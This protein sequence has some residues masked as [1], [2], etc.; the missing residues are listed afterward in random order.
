MARTLDGKVALVTGGGTVILS[1][2]SATRHM[3]RI[4]GSRR[5]MS[6]H[7]STEVVH[8]AHAVSWTETGARRWAVADESAPA[9]S[10]G[11]PVQVFAFGRLAV[12]IDGAP[13]AF[14]GKT[15][16][17]PIAMLKTILAFG[18]RDVSGRQMTDALWPRRRRS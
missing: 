3:N 6:N 5:A 10:V 11:C 12:V 15:P 2:A 14:C 16:K 13:L 17:R 18:G 1:G 9:E 7:P 8:G 4:R